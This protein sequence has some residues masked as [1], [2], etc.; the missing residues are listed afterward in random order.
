MVSDQL[1]GFVILGAGLLL[2]LAIVFGVAWRGA[3]AAHRP[4]PPRGVHLPPPSLLPLVL[5]VA[6]FL[7]G[8]GLAFR[9]E[10]W[11][12][13]PFLV[14]PGLLVLVAGLIAWV[15]AADREWV[16]TEH[17]PHDDPAH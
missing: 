9:L 1:I 14:V 11:A 2:V 6:A 8:A 5:S 4:R 12:V 10:G 7:I 15:R 13:N 16:E 17:G 3:A